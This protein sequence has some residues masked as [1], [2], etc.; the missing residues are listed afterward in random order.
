MRT[1]R[2][3]D[4][5][6]VLLVTRVALDC[7]QMDEMRKE[8][9]YY[10]E[11]IF[12]C[13]KCTFFL[14]DKSFKKLDFPG[15]VCRGFEE[16]WMAK[17]VHYYHQMDPHVPGLLYNPPIVVTE[18]ITPFRDL[19]QTEYYQDFLCLWVYWIH[20]S[21]EVINEVLEHNVSY[22]FWLAASAYHCDRFWVEET[23]HAGHFFFLPNRDV[24]SLSILILK[25]THH[26]ITIK[27][28]P[29]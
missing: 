25:N 18:Q 14:G 27:N 11:K 28:D 1:L 24:A 20:F 17:F 2:D 10:L 12:R 23:V 26:A 21:L 16:D 5:K 8:V 3:Q 15:V 19:M 4:L 7:D 9:L 13:D 22:L 6:D 29:R